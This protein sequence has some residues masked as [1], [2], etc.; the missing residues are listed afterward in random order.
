MSYGLAIYR[1]NASL[2]YSSAD[3]TWNQVDTLYVPGGGTI[4]VNY[5]LLVGRETLC[6]QM[7]V[8]QPP[9]NRKATAHTIT[10]SGQNITISGG[11]ENAYFWVLMR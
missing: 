5:P 4:S 1:A 2:V 11:S 8:D 10:V 3:V 7:M 9:L 6:V